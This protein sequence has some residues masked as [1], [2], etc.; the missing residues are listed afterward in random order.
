VTDDRL[1]HLRGVAAAL[2]P[3]PAV[4]TLEEPR[5]RDG[6]PVEEFLVL[7]SARRPRL[8][9]P[10]GRRA[11]AAV[12]RQTGVGRSRPDRLRATLLAW[13]LRA[14]LGP[15]VSR[16]RLRI[17]G[18]DGETS[19]SLL[20]HVAD[21]LGRD[22]QMGLQ[23]TP[24]RAN[25]KPVLHLVDPAGHSLAY[26]KLGVDRLTDDL[27]R[28]EAAALQTLAEIRTPAF[29]VPE[30]LHAGPWGDHELL[31]QSALPSW[32][33]PRPLSAERLLTA[34]QALSSVGR[35]DGRLPESGHWSDLT[36]R[37]AALPATGSATRLRALT[38]RLVTAAGDVP[39]PV[40]AGHGDWAPWNMAC[41][42]D[43]LLVWDW[44]RFRPAVPVGSDLLH[45]G[46][47]TDL[48][49]RGQDPVAAATRLVDGAPVRLASLGQSPRVARAVAV[50]YL[51]DLATR[52]LTD[53]QLEA[54]ARLGDVDAYLLPACDR[55]LALLEGEQP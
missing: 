2:W 51:A 3:A 32:L 50:L 39:I 19:R 46:L 23:L 21:V 29:T 18:P 8:V 14:G 42:Q 22:V 44:E 5:R 13:G 24:P 31:V 7:P 38:R 25:R 35:T 30:L 26:V 40:G 55:G 17:S 45:H 10:T 15:V 33:P 12:A 43:G 37:I 52:Y 36:T 54:G 48:V 9:T 47:Q 16:R 1:A 6:I 11:A 34:V 20:S 4:A 27:V 53:R 49:V 28:R 41:V